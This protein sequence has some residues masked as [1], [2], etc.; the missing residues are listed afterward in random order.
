VNGIRGRRRQVQPA[1]AVAHECLVGTERVFMQV[2]AGCP[3]EH[4]TQD[5]RLPGN[6][7]E[8]AGRDVCVDVDPGAL[9][10]RLLQCLGLLHPMQREGAHVV[11]VANVQIR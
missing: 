2:L 4:P 7:T 8:L 5:D 11:V 6:D 3:R 1:I 10:S 9:A